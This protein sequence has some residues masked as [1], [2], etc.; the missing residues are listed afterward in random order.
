MTRYPKHILLT[1]LAAC[2]ILSCKKEDP[3]SPAVRSCTVNSVQSQSGND[4]RGHITTEDGSPAATAEFILTNREAEP[5]KV[6]AIEFTAPVE[7]A[8]AFNLT[9]T[10][11]TAAGGRKTITLNVKYGENIRNGESAKFYMSLMPFKSAGG[12]KVIVHG[13]SNGMEVECSS[14]VRDLSFESGRTTTQELDFTRTGTVRAGQYYVKVSAEP[15]NWDGTYLIVASEGSTSYAFNPLSTASSPYRTKVSVSGGRILS[16]EEVDKYAVTAVRDGG[17]H[18]KVTSKDAYDVIN[19]EGYYVFFSSSEIRY[20]NNNMRNSGHYCH[21]FT[22]DSGG[23]QMMSAKMTTGAT[24]YYLGYSSSKFAYVSGAAS[25]RVQLYRL[26]GEPYREPVKNKASYDL[27]SRNMK[28][29]LDE[30]ESRYHDNDWKTVSV[31]SRYLGSGEGYDVPTPVEI[32]WMGYSSK[33]KTVSVYNDSGYADFETS[34]TTQ[35]SKGVI[36]N[37]IPGRTYWYRVV[38]TDGEDVAA[39]SFATEGRRR[40]LRIS[41]TVNRDNANNCRDFG[42][43]KTVDGHTLKYGMAFRGSNMSACTQEELDYISGYMN[44]GADIDLRLNNG[45]DHSANAFPV[46]DESKVYYSYAGY[47]SWAHLSDKSKIK[48]TFTDIISTL[49]KGK[50]VYIH[51]RVGADRTGY[52]CMLMEAALGVSQKDCS[53]DYELTSLSCV[54]LRDRTCTKDYYFNDGMSYIQNYSKG[55]SFQEKAQNILLDAGIT[56][57]QLEVLKKAMLE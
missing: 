28:A 31:V 23:V 45:S 25:N 8:G 6:S 55:S 11:W 29:Y 50:A 38:T 46:F 42:G 24:Q 53:M 2:T 54:G 51:C 30:A 15:Q 40:M 39:G 36:Y 21:T 52:I 48:K 57:A 9:G 37:L 7:I 33:T 34:V 44:V 17:K 56:Q 47:N 14:S 35:Q 20:M 5:L 27:E 12:C 22:Y 4:D 10:E 3:D 16:T 49:G 32:G 26:D 41:T 43:Q 19:S 13:T 18:V 1:L